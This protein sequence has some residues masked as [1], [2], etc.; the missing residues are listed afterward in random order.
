MLYLVTKE[1]FENTYQSEWED[2]YATWYLSGS[3]FVHNVRWD[4]NKE[5]VI[6]SQSA[7]YP[8]NPILTFN[9]PAERE[10]WLWSGREYYEWMSEEERLEEDEY[11]NDPYGMGPYPEGGR[12]LTDMVYEEP[13][14]GSV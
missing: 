10:L 6:F 14:S 5:R 9:N 8:C 3:N 11:E 4:F 1:E 2:T 12:P 13:G 7:D